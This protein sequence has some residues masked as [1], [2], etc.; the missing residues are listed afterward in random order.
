MLL[1]FGFG[2]IIAVELPALTGRDQA[3]ERRTFWVLLALGFYMSLAAVQGW[4]VPTPT[5][6]LEALFRP[7]SAVLGLP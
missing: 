4:P 6:V 2:V 3:G 7:L 5:P 1:L